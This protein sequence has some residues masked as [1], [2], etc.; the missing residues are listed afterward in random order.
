MQAAINGMTV[1][2]AAMEIG[3][4]GRRV[5]QLVKDG[6][7]RGTQLHPRF[8]VLNREDVATYATTERKPGPKPV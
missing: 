1:R 6:T 5:L 2:E 7:I 4:S 3:V 8:W